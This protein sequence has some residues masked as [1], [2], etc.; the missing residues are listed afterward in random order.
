MSITF[1]T[2]HILCA[3]AIFSVSSLMCQVKFI[4]NVIEFG[5]HI[6]LCVRLLKCTTTYPNHG[7]VIFTAAVAQSNEL[8]KHSESTTRR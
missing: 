4:R 1:G 3:F 5:A 7:H 2:E 8:L 6:D